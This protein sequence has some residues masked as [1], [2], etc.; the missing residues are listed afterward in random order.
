MELNGINF[1]EIKMSVIC[2][3]QVYIDP[4][5]HVMHVTNFQVQGGNFNDLAEYCYEKY[6]QWDP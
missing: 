2:E 3:G 5:D 6:F 1:E 4:K